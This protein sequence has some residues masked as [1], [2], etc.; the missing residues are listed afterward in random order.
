MILKVPFAYALYYS[1]VMH[2]LMTDTRLADFYGMK[3]NEMIKRYRKVIASYQK[4]CVEEIELKLR[5]KV[6]N[7]VND[8]R[9]AEQIGI[10]K[11]AIKGKGR[12]KPIRKLFSEIQTLL[13][14]LAPCMLMNPISVAQYIAIDFPKF[15][16]V[17]FDE[18]SQI[19]TSEA[20]GAIARGIDAVVVGDPKQMPPTTFFATEVTEVDEDVEDMESLLIDCQTISMPVTELKWHY[21]SQHESLIAFSNVKY[22]GSNLYTFPTP[23]DLVSEVKIV[24][25]EG[26]YDRKTGCNKAE[27]Q[28]IVAEILRRY[29]DPLLRK[30]SIGVITFNI[31]QQSYIEDLLEKTLH[32]PENVDLAGYNISQNVFIKNLENVQGDEA[33]VILF[34]IGYAP[35]KDG[36]LTMNFG[37]LNRDGGWRRLNVAVSRSRREM[38]VYSVLRPEQIRSDV[39]AQGVR[40]LKEFLDYAENRK[41]LCSAKQKVEAADTEYIVAE[42]AHAIKDM[43]YEVSCDIGNSEFKMD[44]GVINPYN[45]EQYLLGILLDSENCK[46]AATARDRFVLQPDILQRLGWKLL[47]LWVLDW[48]D[49][50]LQVKNKLQT[51][52]AAERVQAQQAYENQQK[53]LAEQKTEQQSATVADMDPEEEETEEVMVQA[54]G[55]ELQP[56][57]I[58]PQEGQVKPTIVEQEKKAQDEAVAAEPPKAQTEAEVA[59]EKPKARVDSVLEVEQKKAQA[60]TPVAVAEQE[61]NT[62][63]VQPVKRKLSRRGPKEYKQANIKIQGEQNDFYQPANRELIKGVIEKLL[64]KE[65]PIELGALRERVMTLWGF[66]KAGQKF[67][68]SFAD[69][70]CSM[71]LCITHDRDKDFVWATGQQP[72]EYN[73]YRD[74]AERSLQQVCTQELL[75][76]MYVA[77]RENGSLMQEDLLRETAKRFGCNKFTKAV[78]ETFSFVL[79]QGLR[80]EIFRVLNNGKVAIFRR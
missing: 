62:P 8:N 4:A 76:G 80:E 18:A 11:K 6:A 13:P 37:P 69:L 70:L 77:A 75:N 63:A 68:N 57:V 45:P 10:L 44:I 25:P 43:G 33:D 51:L 58:K 71:Q 31:K 23:D 21:R 64:A 9:Y 50:P 39:S 28:A 53:A 14:E 30:S 35:D 15:D 2:T 73:I 65:A 42:I 55:A 48:L 17:V 7:V 40:N 3:Y 26:Y 19:P 38:V 61:N 79:Q 46:E 47:R 41:T 5:Y 67:T 49:D 29:R 32:M 72:E 54:E 34:S 16:L 20:V 1:L 78:E 24:H 27:A 56:S 22:Y 74:M 36:R 66:N 12:N 60:E 52:L 59:A